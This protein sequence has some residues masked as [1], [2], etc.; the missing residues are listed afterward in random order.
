M[1]LSRVPG[2]YARLPTPNLPRSPGVGSLGR[3]MDLVGDV[4][5][6]HLVPD[7][8]QHGMNGEPAS[9]PAATTLGK[10]DRR[11]RPEPGGSNVRT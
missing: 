2:A 10:V 1:I 11:I 5:C 7:H 8:M 9:R 6:L 4:P 3:G